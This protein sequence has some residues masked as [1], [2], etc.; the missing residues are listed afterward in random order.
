MKIEASGKGLGARILDL[1]LSRP[2]SNDDFKTILRALGAHGVLCFP[3]QNLETDAF[4]RFGRLFGD[5]EINVANQFHEPDHPE[6]MILSNMTKDGKPV[7]LGDAGQGWHTDMSYSRDIALANILYAIKVPVRDGRSLGAT[8][9]RNMHA[10]YD[11]LPADIKRM[12]A[13]RTATHDFV[14]FWDMMRARPGSQRAPLTPEQ[15]AKKPAVS[16]PIFRTHPITGKTILYCN[17]GYAMWIDGMPKVESDAMLDYLFKHQEQD[18][19][20]HAHAWTEGDVLMWDNIG[21]VHNAVP[22]YRPDERALHSPRASDG[23]EGLCGSGCLTKIITS[24]GRR[25]M[26]RAKPLSLMLGLALLLGS[27]TAAVAQV[28]EIRFARQ[29]SMGYLQ[30]NLMEKFQLIEKHAKAAGLPEVKVTWATFNSP[31]AMNDALL[32]GSV[33]IVSGGVPGLLTIWARTQGTANAVKGIAAFTSQPVL[34]NTRNP[35]VKTIADFTDKDKIA[36]PAVKVS[37][38]AMLLQMAAAKQW[39]AAEF[40][41]LDPMTVG[42]SPPNSTIALLSDS[43]DITSVFSVPPFQAQQLEKPGIRTVLNSYDVFDGPHSFTV[44]WTSSQFRDKNPALYKALVAAYEEATQMLNTDVTPAVQHWI[45]SSKSKIP[46][47]KVA[48]MASGRQVKWTMAPERTTKF[49]D[50][51]HSVG[52]IKVKPATWK[53]LFFPEVHGLPGS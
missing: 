23:D 9:F 2:V 13:G 43:A 32:S 46:L 36:V 14:K 3:K 30:F 27:M 31:A 18:K 35:A 15:R 26:Q 50:F 38:Q 11:D 49:A 45:D 28:P 24:K 16:Q 10:A 4:A 20:F 22:D 1:D 51:M 53:D 6:V 19:F 21:T 37:L 44:S 33:D 48:A 17:P 7:G 8:Q 34:L 41:K 52:S 12:L 29:T 42:M 47:E 5:L 39:G 25:R 40:A